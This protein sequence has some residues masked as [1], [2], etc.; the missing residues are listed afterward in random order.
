MI[1]GILFVFAL[2]TFIGIGKTLTI[3]FKPFWKFIEINI[4][5]LTQI[6]EP[7]FMGL[8]EQMNMAESYRYLW[9]V[10]LVCWER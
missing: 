6:N 9:L 8:F 4:Q 7:K 1:S 10:L 3:N 2:P 5:K